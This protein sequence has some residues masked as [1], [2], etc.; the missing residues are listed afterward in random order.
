MSEKLICPR[1]NKD[2]SVCRIRI[3]GSDE[4]ILAMHRAAHGREDYTLAMAAVVAI[5]DVLDRGRA[6]GTCVDQIK[7]IFDHPFGK[8][9][10]HIV[11]KLTLNKLLKQK[12]WI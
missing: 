12:G 11:S 1:C 2:L 6:C 8:T 5:K 4:D 10:G 9:Y 7:E 3:L